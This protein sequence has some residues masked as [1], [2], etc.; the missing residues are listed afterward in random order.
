MKTPVRSFVSGPSRPDTHPQAPK[1]RAWEALTQTHFTRVDGS[2]PEKVRGQ[3]AQP[4]GASF[5][6][7]PWH[8]RSRRWAGATLYCVPRAAR[9]PS[10]AHPP[11]LLLAPLFRL[12][13]S[14]SA[15]F[16][17]A[18]SLSALSCWPSLHCSCVRMRRTS[19]RRRSRSC[20]ST[21]LRVYAVRMRR[22]TSAYLCSGFLFARKSGYGPRR[23]SER[24]GP[25]GLPSRPPCKVCR[26]RRR[27][28][29]RSS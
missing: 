12:E 29:C 9:A 23:M 4:S 25:R 6:G 17:Q 19:R 15:P 11:V 14:G 7:A 1:R 26:C 21:P 20:T 10:L 13:L 22:R 5:W 27:S 24:G 3:G 2:L 28:S 8:R 18:R 16:F